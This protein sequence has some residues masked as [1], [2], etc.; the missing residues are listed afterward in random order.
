MGVSLQN[1]KK[2]KRNWKKCGLTSVWGSSSRRQM[3]HLVLSF[4]S[5][6]KKQGRVETA[7]ALLGRAGQRLFFKS[8]I[9]GAE[10]QK[11]RRTAEAVMLLHEDKPNFL[12]GVL[13]ASLLRLIPA[14]TLSPKPLPPP[15]VKALQPTDKA[16]YEK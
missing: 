4:P 11:T 9:L 14:I 5:F 1:I 8:E 13:D 10:I 7:E 3:C 16:S 6:N 2:G 12:T 15:L